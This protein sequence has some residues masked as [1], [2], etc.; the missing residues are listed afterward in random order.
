MREVDTTL[1]KIKKI[2]YSYCSLYAKKINPVITEIIYTDLLVIR[3]VV[4]KK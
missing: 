2:L 4:T 1:M 3:Y